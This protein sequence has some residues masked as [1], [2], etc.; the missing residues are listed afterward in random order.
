VTNGKN[1]VRVVGSSEPG[2]SG[3]T[4]VHQSL[5]RL[6]RIPL[7]RFLNRGKQLTLGVL[8]E[9]AAN[10]GNACPELILWS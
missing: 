5:C 6:D 2:S 10:L 1:N 3:S 8:R 9:T 7:S 4:D